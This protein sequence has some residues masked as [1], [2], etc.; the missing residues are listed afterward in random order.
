MPNLIVIAGPNGAGK[1]T[2]APALLQGTLRVNEFVNA[3]AIAQG[4]SAFAPER[5]AFQAGRIMLERLE[6][7]AN[8][9]V[10]FAFETTLASRTF[11]PWIANLQQTGYLFNLIF[12]WLPSAEMAIARVQ[13]RVTQ[14][15]H[16]VPKETIQR[17]YEAGIRNFFELYRPL[18]DSWFF[19][20]NPNTA[21]PRL[22]A[23]GE[24]ESNINIADAQ[25]WQQIEE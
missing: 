23:A 21:N 24:K 14:G 6:Q 22:L 2:V 16:N 5:V 19:Y 9:Q 25:T 12:L 13:Q 8:Q 1:S 7:L 3:D 4:L 11:A 18:A 10:N 17:R 20:D 15:G